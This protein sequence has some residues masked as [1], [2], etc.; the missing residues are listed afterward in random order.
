VGAIDEA[1]RQVEL[2]SIPQVFGQVLEDLVEHSFAL[3]FLKA[4]M[5]RLMRRIPRRKVRPR[6]S[7]PQYPQDRVNYITRLAPRPSSVTNGAI[8]LLSWNELFDRVP[9]LVS[10]IHPTGQTSSRADGKPLQIMEQFRSLTD[11]AEL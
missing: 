5:H 2:S 8:E 6:S 11:L 7:R 10:E 4:S 1:F 3:P 9:L